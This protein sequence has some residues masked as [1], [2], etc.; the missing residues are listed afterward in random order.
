MNKHTNAIIGGFQS[1]KFFKKWSY[2]IGNIIQKF[3]SSWE[4]NYALYL[5]YLKKQWEIISWC[6]NTTKFKF[7]KTIDC[8]DLFRTE[9]KKY[10][11]GYIPDFLVFYPDG[12][13]TIIEIKWRHGEK[14]KRQLRQFQKDFWNLEFKLIDRVDMRRIQKKFYNTQAPW[15]ETWQKIP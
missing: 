4:Y 7:S 10:I 2:H 12:R 15:F 6:K 9:S 14:E 1:D 8:S 3:D 11:S 13:Y 5:E